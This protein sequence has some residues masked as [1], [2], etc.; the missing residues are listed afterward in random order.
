MSEVVEDY[1]NG[2]LVDVP[3]REVAPQISVRSQHQYSYI[4]DAL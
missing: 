1:T 4:L 3:G 2:S